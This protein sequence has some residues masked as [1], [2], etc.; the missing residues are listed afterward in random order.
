[1]SLQQGQEAGEFYRVQGRA[2]VMHVTNMW[3]D[4]VVKQIG[5]AHSIALSPQFVFC[6]GSEGTIRSVLRTCTC[7]PI[8][9][10]LCVSLEYQGMKYS[11][12]SNIFDTHFVQTP[13]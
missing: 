4:C 2:C 9:V 8:Y 7:I 6:A 12:K 1:M 11:Q 13:I 3:Y 10:P 5:A